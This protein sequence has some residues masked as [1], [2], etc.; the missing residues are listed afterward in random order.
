M[1]RCKDRSWQREIRRIW[2]TRGASPCAFEHIF[3]GNLSEDSDGHPVAGGLSEGREDVTTNL[4]WG[5]TDTCNV[6]IR[7]SSN[8]TP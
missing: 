2:F 1:D 7:N 6:S 8:W 5:E 3:V 4:T